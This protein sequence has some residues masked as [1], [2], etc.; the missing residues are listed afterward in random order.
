MKEDIT[1]KE[2]L[3]AW[4]E[5][6]RGVYFSGEELAQ[7]IGVTRTAVWKGVKALQSEGY[8]IDAVTNKGYCL[9]AHTDILSV[10][11]IKKYLR[12]EL[13]DADICLL[14]QVT[15]TNTVLREK[16]AAAPQ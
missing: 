10:Q 7:A 5:E 8:A 15:S 6:N 3:L 9:S 1:T 13:A 4:L 2:K 16:A 11:G 14:P 12:S